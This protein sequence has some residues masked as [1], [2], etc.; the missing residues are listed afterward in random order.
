M[1]CGFLVKFFS[2]SST[3]K[4]NPFTTLYEIHNFHLESYTSLQRVH[5]FWISENRYPVLHYSSRTVWSEGNVAT[6]ITTYTYF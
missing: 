1:L 6:I 2:V 3:T 4:N 5:S